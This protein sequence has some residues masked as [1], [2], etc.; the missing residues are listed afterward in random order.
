MT[1]PLKAAANRPFR[2]SNFLAPTFLAAEF[3][4]IWCGCQRGQRRW[5]LQ[6]RLF[7]CFAGNGLTDYDL[8]SSGQP[9]WWMFPGYVKDVTRASVATAITDHPQV[10]HGLPL[11]NVE[12][13]S[14]PAKKVQKAFSQLY[15]VSQLL[16]AKS[17]QKRLDSWLS[18]SVSDHP[19][20]SS[21]HARL[22]SMFQS[23]PVSKINFLKPW[24]CMT[25]FIA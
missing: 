16:G 24:S 6:G 21:D 7:N 23:C 13:Q 3:C 9:C 20:T 2:G 19:V 10:Y 22:P 17:E 15:M 14:P 8:L 25:H 4:W 1:S 18:A 11:P 12:S 5:L